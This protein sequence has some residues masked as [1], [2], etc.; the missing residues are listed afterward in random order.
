PFRADQFGEEAKKV[1]SKNPHENMD[2]GADMTYWSE[3][4]RILFATAEYLAGQ[5]FPDEMIVSAWKHRKTGRTPQAGDKTG[6]QH[7]ENARPRVLAWLNERLRMGFAEWNAPGYYE[8]DL[9]PLLN[10]ADFV[11]D[12]DIRTRASM[13]LDL[14]I[15]DMARFQLGGAMIA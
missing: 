11:V 6:R 5:H 3:N 9:L 13:V 7:M 2:D 4:H 10:L 15:F 1:R 12:D 14:I 8:E